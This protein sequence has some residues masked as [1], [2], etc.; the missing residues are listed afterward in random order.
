[1]KK[2]FITLTV[3]L[4]GLN[5]TAQQND[6]YQ[7]PDGLLATEIQF[8]PFSNDFKTFKMAQ[9]KAR[10]FLDARNVIRFG[11]GLGIDNDKSDK[12]DVEDSRPVDQDNYTIKRTEE[13]TKNKRSEF[14]ISLGYENHFANT[15]RLDFYAGAEA[16]YEGKYYSG[17]VNHNETFNSVSNVTGERVESSSVTTKVTEYEKMLPDASKY[18]EHNF[19]GNIFTGVDFY[20]YKGLYIG[21]ELGLS[22]KTGKEV[23][24]TWTEKTAKKTITGAATTVDWVETFSTK[25]GVRTHV[26]NLDNNNNTTTA[27]L[28]TDRS[29]TNTK[30]KVYVEPAIRLGWIF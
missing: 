15:G 25:T 21:T 24:G 18:N 10:L 4:V 5:A 22:F 16:G 2:I 29:A 7:L 17:T 13:T 8:N 20:I 6:E 9:L 3:A 14:K 27:Q 1:M 23:N 11:V 28:V 30:L 26:D 19:F 12:N